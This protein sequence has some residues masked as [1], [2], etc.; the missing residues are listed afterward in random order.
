VTTLNKA[1]M[2]RDKARELLDGVDGVRGIGVTWDEDGTPCVRVNVTHA[3]S[4]EDL[5]RIPDLIEEVGVLIEKI[6][7]IALEG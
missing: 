4:E 5:H 6:N 2:A 3:I 1:Y 7:S